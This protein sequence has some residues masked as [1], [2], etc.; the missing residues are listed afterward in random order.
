MDNDIL[1]ISEKTQ[2]AYLPYKYKDLQK[3]YKNSNNKYDS[4]LDI[5]HDLY[6]IPLKNFK[7][8]AFA[9]FREG[10]KLYMHKNKKDKKP[11]FFKALDL[12]LELMFKYSL[13][14]IIITACR[15]LDELDIYLDCLEEKELSNFTCFEIKNEFI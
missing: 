5:I 11:S 10:F 3:I 7:Y 13:N 8:P 14:P 6:I 9:R 15:N 2:K 1:L 4:I 12:A